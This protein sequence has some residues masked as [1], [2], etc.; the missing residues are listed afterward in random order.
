M[1]SQLLYIFYVFVYI[2]NKI[3]IKI[4]KTVKQK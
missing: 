4:L 3:K 2:T 1:H